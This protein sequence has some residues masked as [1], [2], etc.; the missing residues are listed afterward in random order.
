MEYIVGFAT[1]LFMG[2]LLLL[3]VFLAL[4][5]HDAILGVVPRRLSIYREYA[6]DRGAALLTGA[7]GTVGNALETLANATG[8]PTTD[9]RQTTDIQALCLVPDG[10]SDDVEVGPTRQYIA[11][12]HPPIEAVL[13]RI[14]TGIVAHPPTD[15]RIDRLREPD[16]TQ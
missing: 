9:L 4:S 10:I 12:T 14:P 11:D 5:V 6:A 3:S 2:G 16:R 15:D 8:R 1:V 7:P 13:Q